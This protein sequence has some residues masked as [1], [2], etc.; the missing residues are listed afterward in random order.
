MA[1]FKIPGWYQLDYEI[2]DNTSPTEVKSTLLKV[3]KVISKLKSLGLVSKWFFLYENDTIRVRMKSDNKKKL[4]EKLDKLSSAEGL[5]Q[6]DKL[7][8]SKYE[9]SDEMMFNIT[10]AS[11]F[12]NIMSEVT[13][14]TIA[15]L[16]GNLSFDNYRVIE[17]LQHCMFNNLITLSL[18]KEEYF[19]V[20][21]LHER[22]RKP[23]DKD[24][25]NKV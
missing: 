9:E 13:K 16:K 6:S 20:Q 5:I 2:S 15:K 14:L 8:F 7:L 12:S 24:F 19:L 21:R 25:E 1:T 17:R 3:D 11:A 23:S 18:K 10:I 22:T 4:K